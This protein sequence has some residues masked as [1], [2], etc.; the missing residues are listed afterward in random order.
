MPVFCSV[1]A[2]CLLQNDH[3]V[4]AARSTAASEEPAKPS[5]DPWAFMHSCTAV[6]DKLVTCRSDKRMKR[7]KSHWTAAAQRKR[8]GGR[9]ALEARLLGWERRDGRRQQCAAWWNR[10]G[11]GRHLG[12]DSPLVK[13]AM[14]PK[15]SCA[16]FCR[17]VDADGWMGK[18]VSAD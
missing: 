9:K 7:L 17:A 2:V 5:Q 13:L 12:A 14:E 4:V 8:K 11:A 1:L 16:D 3:S 18:A 15:L 10:E 6:L